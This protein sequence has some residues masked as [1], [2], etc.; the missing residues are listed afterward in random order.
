MEGKI[1][2]RLMNLIIIKYAIVCYNKNE[3]K[4]MHLLSLLARGWI[5]IIPMSQ[6]VRWG[7]DVNQKGYGFNLKLPW[8]IEQV[9][10]Q[11]K[12]KNPNTNS[13]LNRKCTSLYRP[14]VILFIV[15]WT[16]NIKCT[17]K[18]VNHIEYRNLLFH[19]SWFWFVWASVWRR[20][21]PIDEIPLA[22]YWLT[23]LVIPDIFTMWALLLIFKTIAHVS[24]KQIHQLRL[25]HSH[26]LC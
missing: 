16:K 13:H 20:K 6:Q 2:V 8:P 1:N 19:F 9:S 5:S 14:L 24:Y 12:K 26:L 18:A 15:Y 17:F 23:I 11:K 22:I 7:G 3:K 4:K 21:K 10:N 25:V